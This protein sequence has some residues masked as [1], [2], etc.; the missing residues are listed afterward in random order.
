M[1]GKKNFEANKQERLDNGIVDRAYGHDADDNKK[2]SLVTA[3]TD[4]AKA[5]AF[6]KSDVL[7]KKKR[8]RRGDRRA[9]TVSVHGSEEILISPFLFPLM[10]KETK[11]SSRFDKA[12]RF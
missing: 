3:V 11:R 12:T 9:K 8:S 1:S 5:F 2:V 6:Y 10:E 4:T 7:K